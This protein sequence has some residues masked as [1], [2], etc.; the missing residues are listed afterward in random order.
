M[1]I[2]SFPESNIDVSYEK[3]LLACIAH[4]YLVLH[5]PIVP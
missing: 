5:V 1:M 2:S 3:D 4:V